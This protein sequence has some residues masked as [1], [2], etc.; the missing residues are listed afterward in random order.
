MDTNEDLRNTISLPAIGAEVF[1]YLKDVNDRE[2]FRA[3]RRLKDLMAINLKNELARFFTKSSSGENSQSSLRKVTNSLLSAGS[4]GH[5]RTFDAVQ[6][7]GELSNNKDQALN[8]SEVT[9]SLR[10]WSRDYRSA[11]GALDNN[12]KCINSFLRIQ[13][14]GNDES[15]KHLLRVQISDYSEFMSWNTELRDYWTRKKLV[16]DPLQGA[17]V[18][19]YDSFIRTFEMNLSNIKFRAFLDSI[20]LKYLLDEHKIVVP[21]FDLVKE[22]PVTRDLPSNTRSFEIELEVDK[23]AINYLVKCYP[24]S[25]FQA[26]QLQFKLALELSRFKEDPS[27]N[28]RVSQKQDI[29]PTIVIAVQGVQDESNISNIVFFLESILEKA[30]STR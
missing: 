2:S 22:S 30:K 18:A 20:W 24:L 19:I 10:A 9:D 8:G 12:F 15:V 11:K 13:K 6:E 25:S 27:L 16:K 21:T 17:Y 23:G 4:S 26:S 29:V 7:L 3:S 1:T 5:Q 14:T 28:F